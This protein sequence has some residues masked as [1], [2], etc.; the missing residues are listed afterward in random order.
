MVVSYF[1]GVTYEVKP[2]VSRLP[3]ELISRRLAQRLPTTYRPAIPSSIADATFSLPS[4][5]A[6][7]AEDAARAIARLDEYASQALGGRAVIPLTSVLLRSESASSSQIENLTVSARQLAISAIGMS[8]S[9]NAQMVAG[10][11]AA[12]RAAIDLADRLG[13]PAILAI[14]AILLA[15]QPLAGPGQ[16]RAVPVWIGPSAVSPDGAAFVPPAPERVPAGMQDLAAFLG[17]A[18]LPV[19]MHAAVAHAQFETIHPFVDGNG[20][21]G[22]ALLQAMLRAAG[23]MRQAIVPVSAGLLSDMDS[24]IA[25]LTAFRNGDYA[26]IVE[27]LAQAC[28]KAASLGRWLVDE[29]AAL[30]NARLADVRP[31]AGSAL[32][33]LIYHVVGQPA[34]TVASV[35]AALQVSEAA[36]RRAVNQALTAGL[37]TATNDKQ[38]NRVWI[39][40]EVI[41]ILNEFA[42]RSG[43]RAM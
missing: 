10:N 34:V 9:A 12:T 6:A 3:D 24:Y 33:G 16:W 5:L 42:G 39:D 27:C 25:A 26:K 11:V 1:K 4:D 20:R 37:L 32:Q 14:H 36:A 22:R 43:R 30:T 8:A 40:G 19:V 2:W 17:R 41:D 15:G 7:A 18:D 23:V 21:T 13:T 31:R 38:R 35:S 28:L 29:L